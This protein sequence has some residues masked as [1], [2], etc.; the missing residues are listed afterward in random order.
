MLHIHSYIHYTWTSF[1][2]PVRD[3]CGYLLSVP[4]CMVCY[5]IFFLRETRTGSAPSDRH[6]LQIFIQ[7]FNFIHLLLRGTIAHTD[8]PTI[9][10][11]RLFGVK[12]DN[13]YVVRR[14]HQLQENVIYWIPLVNML[15]PR[16]FLTLLDFCLN[17]SF[18]ENMNRRNS[19]DFSKYCNQWTRN[20]QTQMFS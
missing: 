11:S 13:L 10:P 5:Y 19:S 20:I 18:I 3:A 9:I 16:S 15:S 1:Y 12:E 8:L 2:L 14:T 4:L 7:N 17:Y 6:S